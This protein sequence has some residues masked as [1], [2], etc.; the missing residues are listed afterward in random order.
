MLDTIS[1]YSLIICVAA[2]LAAGSHGK[3]KGDDRF[4]V[5]ESSTAIIALFVFIVCCV[6]QSCTGL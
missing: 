3:V 1:T 2:L 6:I 4:I 5:Y